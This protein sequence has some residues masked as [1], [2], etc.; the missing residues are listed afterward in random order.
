MGSVDKKLELITAWQNRGLEKGASRAKKIMKTVRTSIKAIA[1]AALAAATAIAGVG[2]ALIKLGRHGAEVQS[3]EDSFDGFLKKANMAPDTLQKVR[4]VLSGTVDD[5]TI[6]QQSI[7][8]LSAGLAPDRLVEFWAKAKQMADVSSRPTIEMFEGLTRAVNKLEVESLET[9]GITLKAGKVYEDWGKKIGKTRKEMTYMDEQMAFSAALEKKFQKNFA[10]VGNVTTEVRERFQQVTADLKNMYNKFTKYMSETP[11]IVEGLEKIHDKFKDLG[12]WITDN[13][14]VIRS[15]TNTTIEVAE[16]TLK[17]TAKLADAWDDIVMI[18]RAIAFLPDKAKSLV[19]IEDKDLKF[20][21]T[22]KTMIQGPGVTVAR[23]MGRDNFLYNW[24]ENNFSDEAIAEKERQMKPLNIPISADYKDPALK[25]MMEGGGAATSQKPAPPGKGFWSWKPPEPDPETEAVQMKY[26]KTIELDQKLLEHKE[27]YYD[28]VSEMATRSAEEIE[29]VQSESA[30]GVIKE[31]LALKEAYIRSLSVM[32][33]YS[34]MFY[35]AEGERG[36]VV[37]A[38]LI[39]MVGEMVSS[40][41]MGKAKQAAIDAAY[42]A[43]QAVLHGA[44]GDWS[45]AAQFG[46]AAAKFTAIAGTAAAGAAWATGYSQEKAAGL[47]PAPEFEE[48]D[49]SGAETDT[50]SARERQ[51]TEA[52]G[53]VK[54]RPINITISSQT[55]INTG[56]AVFSGDP[57]AIADYYDQYIRPQI[58]E[59]VNTGILAIPA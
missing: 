55:N 40:Y 48:T 1:T 14:D 42:A 37:N 35:K 49:F 32:D 54:Q 36:R 29:M 56:V 15:F 4:Y 28:A 2:T 51:T 50:E 5:M 6:M 38:M 31:A 59:D 16:E 3:V 26:D 43:A 9:I 44:A 47:A 17:A 19:G 23:D 41:L 52:T 22:I 30:K 53:V 7:Q 11:A 57:D 39:D 10:D 27:Q 13:Q 34:V 25:A 46:I 18:Y 24:L 45:G 20:W 8:A 12:D 21:E 58:Q 33:K